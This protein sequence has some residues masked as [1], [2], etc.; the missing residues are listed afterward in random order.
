M[1]VG[2]TVTGLPTDS[3]TFARL[4]PHFSSC[5]DQVEQAIS[6]A[7]PGYPGSNHYILEYALASL[8]YHREYL[9]K[10]LP[11]SHGLFCTPLF[12]TNTMLNKLAD[13]LQ[14]GTLQPHH[15][16]T[17]RPTGVPLYVAILSNMASL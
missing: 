14:G 12:T 8:D 7:F 3:H 9:K 17:L 2:R 1:H 15:E 16:S 11:A 5:D 6:I 13:R 4:P 10:T